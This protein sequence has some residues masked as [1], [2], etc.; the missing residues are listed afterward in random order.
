MYTLIHAIMFFDEIKMLY[1]LVH[2]RLIFILN[3]FYYII[4]GE[5]NKEN[6]IEDGMHGMQV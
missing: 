5:N 2:N 3:I 6:C 4:L 1:N